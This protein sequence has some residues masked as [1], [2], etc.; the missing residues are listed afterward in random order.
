MTDP[1]RP[2]P[3]EFT[4][5]ADS[6]YRSG[7][8]SRSASLKA[9]FVLLFLTAALTAGA[10]P[11]NMAAA[12]VKVA[13]DGSFRV[14][15]RFDVLAF[16]ANATPQAVS[17]AE[18]TDIV[19]APDDTIRARLKEAEGRL[20][21][22]IETG[23][24]LKV[25][26]FPGL[27]EITRV[28]TFEGPR[29][30]LV[31]GN[32]TL[33]GRLPKGVRTIAF[34]FPAALDAVILTTEFPY[35]EPVSEP[36][37]P[38]VRSRQLTLPT[39]EEIAR[40]ARALGVT[41]PSTVAPKA[42]APTKTRQ[43]APPRST[44]PI[45]ETSRIAKATPDAPEPAVTPKSPAQPPAESSASKA[46]PA[47]GTEPTRTV[48][49]N[50]PTNAPDL[51]NA[52]S[53]SSAESSPAETSTLPEPSASTSSTVPL[54]T[55]PSA[56]NPWTD[57][58]RYVKLGFLHIIP[59]GLDH[60]LFV[61]GLVLVARRTKDLLSQVSA[62]TVAHSLT[63]GL[64][65]FGVVRL[66]ERIVEPVI[67][68]SIAF[69]AIENVW[70]K[71]VSPWRLVAVF[72]FGLIHG[73][74]F[75]GILQDAGIAR[76][77]LV[78]ALVGFNVGVELGQFAVVAMAL[79]VIGQFRQKEELYRK[80]IVVPASLAIA[81]LAIFWTAQRLLPE[82]TTGVAVAHSAPAIR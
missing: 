11:A 20:R 2:A 50:A 1:R 69:V 70:A 72:A 61:L 26:A 21:E 73:L 3:P 74:G 16:V 38:G 81:A 5:R 34:R 17:D 44:K 7:A 31:Y 80:R 68:A 10:H 55:S 18:L 58:P 77:D 24:P 79:G 67:A 39:A 60:I 65:L 12:A 48:S 25:T 32:A 33:E 76:G 13:A 54:A 52:P 59:E 66:P 51:S 42:S 41:V 23:T 22:G 37:P 6:P 71:R 47:T 53:P 30:L 78:P 9:F 35:Q 46:A 45:P 43:V 28:R 19:D 4:S 57:I 40:T 27:G 75:A 64:A 63:L 82:P 56:V 14:H 8:G 15:I 29:R 36:L 49:G 62:F